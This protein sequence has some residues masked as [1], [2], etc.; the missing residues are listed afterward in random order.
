[1]PRTPT[2]KTQPS[3]APFSVEA[4][5]RWFILPLFGDDLCRLLTLGDEKKA[6]QELKRLR[7][8][9]RQSPTAR[10]LLDLSPARG[11]GRPE[12]S[13]DK[14]RQEESVRLAYAVDVCHGKQ[15]DILQ[16]LGRDA[17]SG[18]PDWSWIQGR[19]ETGRAAL[20]KIFEKNPELRKPLTLGSVE[21]ILDCPT[22]RR[23][24]SPTY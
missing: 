3:V 8:I 19:L 15:A 17:D 10:T 9:I 7:R 22:L 20:E 23:T 18:S 13:V 6:S 12:G 24:E 16:R 2:T 1:M 4:K 14:V 11:R 5:N 21:E